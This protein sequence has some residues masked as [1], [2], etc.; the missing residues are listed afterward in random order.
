M[1]YCDLTDA[2]LRALT[3]ERR[4][5]RAAMRRAMLP[6]PARYAAGRDGI[7]QADRQRLVRNRAQMRAWKEAQW[8]SGVHTCAYCACAMTMR[9]GRP[10]S[11]TVD[12]VEPLIPE[13]NDAPWNYA[14]ACWAC[15]NRKGRMSAGAFRAL[16]ACEAVAVAAE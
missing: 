6:Q 9:P 4:R 7:V 15:N 12:H 2:D 14:M 3:R 8:D 1:G 10:T 11:A 16:L 13:V 5:A